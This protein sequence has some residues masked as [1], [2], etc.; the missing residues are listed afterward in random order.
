MGRT[1]NLVHSCNET[2]DRNI[3]RSI[4]S[5]WSGTTRK[6]RAREVRACRVAVGVDKTID[7]GII[8][9]YQKHAIFTVTL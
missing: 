7:R 5:S 8:F 1:G 3:R 4:L 9:H 6:V 2:A